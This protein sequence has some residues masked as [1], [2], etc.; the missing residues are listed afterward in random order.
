MEPHFPLLR[1]P[2]RCAFTPTGE[3]DSRGWKRHR[4]ERCRYH[5]VWIP[6]RGQPIYRVCGRQGEG[7][8]DFVAR[9]LSVVG[10]TKPHMEAIAGGNC[11][12]EK[13]QERLNQVGWE[14]SD[15]WA[16]LLQIP[17]SALRTPQ[18][19]P[20]SGDTPQGPSPPEQAP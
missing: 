14:L 17:L 5:T 20:A 3:V 1:S 13:R 12:C 4:C 18:P 15:R 8:G 16:K 19:K 7:L 10:I 2:K 9:W 11:G 6:D